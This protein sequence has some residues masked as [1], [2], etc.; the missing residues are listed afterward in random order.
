MRASDADRDRVAD[1]LREALAEGRL[2]P[3][4]HAERLDA[5]YGAKTHGDLAPI[6]RDLPISLA[7][8]ARPAPAPVPQPPATPPRP[9]SHEPIVAV[10]SEVKRKGRW[11][12]PAESTATAVFGKVELDLREA[13]LEQREV[14]ITANSFFG[15]VEFL[16]PEGVHVHDAGV[17]IFGN[18]AADQP[19]APQPDAPVVRVRGVTLF[20]AV[21]IKRG[22]LRRRRE[23]DG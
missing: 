5:V 21:E 2:T 8:G 14:T 16:V 15:A 7:A 13:V 4:E 1:V 20:G 19:G 3:D 18:R 11:T 10:F 6:T 9:A 12:V 23:Q 22:W 17:A